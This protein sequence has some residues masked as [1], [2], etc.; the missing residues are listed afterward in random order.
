MKLPL[1]A[2]ILKNEGSVNNIGHVTLGFCYLENNILI[3]FK[4]VGTFL[5]GCL[6]CRFAITIY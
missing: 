2:C 4:A 5:S 6:C 3:L 1:V